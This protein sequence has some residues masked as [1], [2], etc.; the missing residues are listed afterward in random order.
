MQSVEAFN[1]KMFCQ[2]T[3]CMSLPC[4]DL[5]RATIFCQRANREC[6][7]HCS[8]Y[9]DLWDDIQNVQEND[10]DGS[11]HGISVSSQEEKGSRESSEIERKEES[12]DWKSEEEEN[13][14]EE[15]N[16]DDED[17]KE[18]EEKGTV[19]SRSCRLFLYCV[20]DVTH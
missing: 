11:V 18:E 1:C 10:K 6:F 8:G 17:Q 5:R 3:V 4:V 20:A 14:D 2:S 7:P 13:G 12:I 16:T 15:D 9:G 19:C